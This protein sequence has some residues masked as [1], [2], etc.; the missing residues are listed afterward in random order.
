MYISSFC[1]RV[2]QLPIS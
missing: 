1:N 2:S